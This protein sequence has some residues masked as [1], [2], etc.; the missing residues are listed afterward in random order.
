MARPDGSMLKT[1]A[2]SGLC[3]ASNIQGHTQL[4]SEDHNVWR[5]KLGLVHV[6]HVQISGSYDPE[7]FLCLNIETFF[8]TDHVP[9][10]ALIELK[11]KRI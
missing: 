5:I 6:N 8:S 11:K 1:T 9:Y 4:F 2:M 10:Q 3:G 7:K